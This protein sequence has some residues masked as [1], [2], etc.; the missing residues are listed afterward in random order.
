[1]LMGTYFVSASCGNSRVI[2]ENGMLCPE[3]LSRH[4]QALWL[5]SALTHR[6]WQH[7]A[8]T[9]RATISGISDYSSCKKHSTCRPA[10]AVW[11]NGLSYQWWDTACAARIPQAYCIKTRLI[12]A[13]AWS[14]S[15]SLALHRHAW[16]TFWAAL[17]WVHWQ[18]LWSL[19]CFCLVW[20]LQRACLWHV[21]EHPAWH[22][23]YS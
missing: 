17:Y 12:T 11:H 15:V 21:S 22:S 9:S 2:N 3:L 19:P 4:W 18:A 8:N 7:H 6:V 10:S 13:P 5:C 20:P 23:I 1:M 14:K 16:W